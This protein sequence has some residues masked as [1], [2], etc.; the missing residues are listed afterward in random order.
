MSENKKRKGNFYN[1]GGPMK[2]WKSPTL[3]IGMTGFLCTCNFKERECIRDTYSLLNEYADASDYKTQEAKHDKEKENTKQ[4]VET[5]INKLEKDREMETSPNEKEAAANESEKDNDV[6]TTPEEQKAITDRSEKDSTVEEKAAVDKSEE[7]SKVETSLEKNE[8]VADESEKVVDE[9]KTSP[10]VE[11]I[12]S[13]D[14]SDEEEENKELDFATQLQDEIKELRSEAT[15]EK[16]LSAVDTGVPNVVFIKATSLRDPLK[17]STAII[18]DIY[19]T[20]QQKS[21]YI[22]RML[23]VQRVCKAYLDDLKNKADSLFDQYFVKEPK[24]FCI[25]FSRHRNN[26]LHREDVIEELAKLINS[27]NPGNKANLKDPEI[28]VVISVLKGVCAISIAPKYF[29]YKKYNLAEL[30]NVKKSE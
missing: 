1:K 17:V 20:K 24:T 6:N 21:R 29:F 10:K 22:L 8:T 13:D 12:A 30:C 23:P 5:V 15:Q 3:E 25:V 18:E 16:R 7:E 19:K 11:K 14:S 26:N 2:K 4:D 28:A 9:I 27:K